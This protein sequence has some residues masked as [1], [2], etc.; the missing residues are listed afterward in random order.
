MKKYADRM[1]E[2]YLGPIAHRG[3]HD[4]KCTENGLKAF[5]NAI[6]AGLPFELD[7]HLSKDGELIVCH[8]AQLK[9]TTG[10]EGRIESLTSHQIRN[11]Y[12]L[13]DGGVVPTFQE[14]LDLNKERSLIVVEL[15]CENGNWKAL[16]KAANK[17][18]G[19]VQNTK[20]IVVIS[21]DP[22][23]LYKTRRFV[24]GLLI[25]KEQFWVW[26]LRGF[27]ESIDIDKDLLENAAVQKYGETH[28]INCWTV[29]NEE[30]AIKAG[31]VADAIT[32]QHMDPKAVKKAL[33]K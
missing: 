14:V 28:F 25:C 12:R 18:L 7:V 1:P 15:K 4:D 23:A 24:R 13:L 32:F 5:E 29:E 8:D 2:E 31:K 11:G 26:R 22:R 27:F 16:A 20:K 21:F 9:R 33:S 19:Q 30:D 3:L 6:N 10:K 17:A